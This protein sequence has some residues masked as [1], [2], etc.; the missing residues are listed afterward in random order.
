MPKGIAAWASTMTG[1]YTESMRLTAGEKIAIATAAREILPAG[2]RV[3]LFGSRVDDARRGGDIDLLIEPRAALDPAE[4]VRL[5]SRLAARL[6]RLI[7]ERRI[8]I[9]LAAPG[10]SDDRLIVAEARRQAVELV[11][12]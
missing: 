9:V 8:D 3:S 5:R 4:Q 11:R 2:A 6:Y 12:T 10:L 7:G 1:R